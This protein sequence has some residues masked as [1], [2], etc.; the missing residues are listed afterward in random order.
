MLYLCGNISKMRRVLF[1]T[2]LLFGQLFGSQIFAQSD[3]VHESEAKTIRFD[4]KIHDF[5]DILISNGSVKC[6]FTFT[7]VSNK[8]IVVHNVI[9]S[10]GCTTPDW[11][12]EPVMPNKSGV[13]NAV[14][15]NDQGPFPFDKTL[16][17]Y[18]SNIDRPVILRIRGYAHESVKDLEELYPNKIGQLGVRKTTLQIGFIDQG[19]AKSDLI[20]IANLSKSPMTIETAGNTPGLYINVTPNPI[21]PQSVAKLTYTVDTKSTTGQLWGKTKMSFTFVING[22][23]N[24]TPILV[25][26][27]IKDNFTSMTKEQM[28]NAP[29]PTS[30]RSYFEFGEVKQGKVLE[31]TFV[32][33]NKGKRDLIIHKVESEQAGV[34][35]LTKCPIV[36]KAGKQGTIKIKFDTSTYNSE[37]INILTMVT[38]SPDK[39][40]M[41]LFITGNVIK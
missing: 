17:V 18:V 20:D 39:P 21:P 28:A 31:H 35:I 6:T 8:P 4:K 34:S 32:I 25:N 26:G 36:I 13:I 12:K 41:N 9:S 40:L 11:T 5:G 7:N 14:F 24:K 29:N 19:S 30:D 1:T 23:E 10:C 37:V 15:T 22:K 27:V 33:K 38:N 3:R 16:T 2:I